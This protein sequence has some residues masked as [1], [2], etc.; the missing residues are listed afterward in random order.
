ME[1]TKIDVRVIQETVINANDAQFCELNDLQLALIG[2]G[3]G[4]PLA[5]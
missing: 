1:H 2:G 5:L 3:I 4:D